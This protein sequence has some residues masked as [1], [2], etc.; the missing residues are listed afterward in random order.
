[1]DTRRSDSRRTVDHMKPFLQRQALTPRRSAVSGLPMDFELAKVGVEGRCPPPSG[2]TSSQ[3]TSTSA[4]S[5][6]NGRQIRR[7]RTPKIVAE[8][9]D[10]AKLPSYLR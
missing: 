8:I 5:T 3:P 1:L 9:R 7:I 6:K 4:C 2:T 10:A